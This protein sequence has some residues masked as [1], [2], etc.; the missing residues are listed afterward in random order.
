MKGDLILH[1]IH[2]TG[3]RI[4]ECGVNGLSRGNTTE[5]V[6]IG[7]RL[8]GYLSLHIPALERSKDLT[9]WI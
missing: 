9:K 7:N 3:K 4:Q 8:L 5:G 2:I 1:V 6:M